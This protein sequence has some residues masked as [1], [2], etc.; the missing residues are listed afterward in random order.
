VPCNPGYYTDSTGWYCYGTSCDGSDSPR[1]PDGKVC[2]NAGTSQPILCQAGT[3]S[4]GERT[5]CVPCNP[6][7]YT[8]STNKS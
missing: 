2:P 6:G 1:C 8:D 5:K 3:I 4:N 7:Y